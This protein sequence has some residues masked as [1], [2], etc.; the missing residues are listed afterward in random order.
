MC[1]I[2]REGSE[3]IEGEARKCKMIHLKLGQTSLITI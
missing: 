3:Q 2:E 1:V